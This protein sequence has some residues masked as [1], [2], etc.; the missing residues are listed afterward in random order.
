MSYLVDSA[1]RQDTLTAIRDA[2][3]ALDIQLNRILYSQLDNSF[4]FDYWTVKDVLAHLS[5]WEALEINWIETV[6]RGESPFLYA[7]GYAR[8][9]ADWCLR[10]TAIDTI[11]AKVLA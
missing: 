5:R 9:A 1:I 4:V 6:A 8:D 11:N 7:P 2:D 3:S 10:I